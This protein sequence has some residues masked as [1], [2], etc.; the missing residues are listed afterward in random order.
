MEQFKKTFYLIADSH[1]AP[2][3]AY[4]VVRIFDE[5]R[6]LVELN[7]AETPRMLTLLRKNEGRFL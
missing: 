4:R 7:P 3:G 1:W 6:V 2:A 5:T